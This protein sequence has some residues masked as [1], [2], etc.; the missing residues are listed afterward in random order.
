MA[1]QNRPADHRASVG[2]VPWPTPQNPLPIRSSPSPPG[3]ARHRHRRGGRIPRD[4]FAAPPTGAAAF[5]APGPVQ[6]WDGVRDAT[7]YGPTAPA[8]RLPAPI[9]A[10]LD[11]AIEFGEDYLNVN[12]WTPDPSASGAAGD[13]LDPRRC[14]QPRSNRL[15]IWQRDAFARD[16]VVLVGVNYRLGS[17]PDS[18]RW[19]AHRRTVGFSS[20]RGA[21]EWVRDNIAAFGG[22]P[23]RVTHL[24]RVGRRDECSVS[25]VVTARAGPV[26]TRDHA[27]QKRIGRRRRR[28]ARKVTARVAGLLGVTPTWP[29]SARWTGPRCS[30]RRPTWRWR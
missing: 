12:V 29:G 19:K 7:A 6:A 17:A 15:S 20:D 9:A 4:T 23:S 28:D 14:L 3:G 22:Y 13:G 18:R 11:N 30:R 5:A 2:W 10:L 1:P 24:R 25:V 27:K 8:G 26:R 21:L 16:G